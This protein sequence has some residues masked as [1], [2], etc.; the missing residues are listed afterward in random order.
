MKHASTKRTKN[1]K[2]SDE[3]LSLLSTPSAKLKEQLFVFSFDRTVFEE[4]TSTGDYWQQ[5]LKSH[6][7]FDHVIT[8]MLEEEIFDPS[9]LKL[10]RMSF[11]SK[12]DM[13]ASLGLIAKE[14]SKPICKINDIRNKCAQQ[15]DFEISENIIRDLT[16]T[17]PKYL[18]EI[19]KNEDG[20][21]QGPIQFYEILRVILFK[22]EIVRQQLSLN[23]A[24][25]KK[26][27]I[28]LRSVLADKHQDLYCE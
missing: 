8:K 18:R 11:S 4:R 12:H 17:T 1:Y 6:L 25:N 24:L 27:K 15:L 10:D 28:R 22:L 2:F 3:D 21:L 9:V 16:N 19:A 26:S 7:Y 5:L 14:L 23:R 20:R 13:A